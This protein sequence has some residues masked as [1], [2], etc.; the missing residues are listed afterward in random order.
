MKENLLHTLLAT[1]IAGV[2]A[3]FGVV[4]IPIVMLV[5]VMVVDYF[6]GMAAAKHLSKFN[7]RIGIFGIVK[8]ICYGA[9]VVVGMCI[10]YLTYLIAS[11]FGYEASTLFFGLLVTIWLIVNELISILEN[12]VKLEVPVPAPLTKILSK[13]KIVAESK[14][15]DKGEKNGL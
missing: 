6:T 13:L 11:Q 8:K 10:D 1:V 9:L 7:S 12:L 2:S 4:A 5:I 3:Y 14:M 15:E